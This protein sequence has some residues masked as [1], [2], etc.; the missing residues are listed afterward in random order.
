MSNNL[1]ISKIAEEQGVGRYLGLQTLHVND[2]AEEFLTLEYANN[3][4]LYVPVASLHL[5]NRYTGGPEESAPLH[6]L[7]SEQWQ[8]IKSKAAEKIRDVAAELLEIYAKRAARP[9]YAYP[10][11]IVEYEAF[12]DSFPFEETEDQHNTI[13]TVIEDMRSSSPMDRVVCGDVGFG[14]TEVAMRAAF[15]AAQAGK[16]VAILSPT[17][18]LTQ[19]HYQNFSDRFADWPIKVDM[20]SRFRSKKETDQTIR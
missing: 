12:A 6:R 16:Q 4:K 10:F 7:G 13:Q 1:F 11:D 8:K 20:L 3:D 5:I 18:L 2:Y 9:G 14:K 15:V 17:T 19:Q